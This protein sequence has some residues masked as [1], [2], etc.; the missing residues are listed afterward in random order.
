M[1]YKWLKSQPMG[2]Y[3]MGCR[4][5]KKLVFEDHSEKDIYQG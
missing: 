1:L 3:G 5:R 4:R 2:Y